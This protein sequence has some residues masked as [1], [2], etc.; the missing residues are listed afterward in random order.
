MDQI[1]LQRLLKLTKI[2]TESYNRL[3]YIKYIEAMTNANVRINK[4]TNS[5]NE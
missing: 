4:F 3:N 2:E 1:I 5:P